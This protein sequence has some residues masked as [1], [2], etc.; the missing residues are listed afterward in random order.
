MTAALITGELRPQQVRMKY[1]ENIAR[2]GK[3]RSH[4]YKHR[5]QT[6]PHD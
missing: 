2:A 1:F 3:L 4:D 6:T 5:Y